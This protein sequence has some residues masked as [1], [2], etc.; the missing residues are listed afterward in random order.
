M[1]VSA[2]QRYRPVYAVAGFYLLLGLVSR[3]LLW[4][5]YGGAADVPAALLPGILAGGLVNDFVE[6]LYLTAPLALC[7]MLLPDR[8][9]RL[10]FSRRLMLAAVAAAVAVLT[11]LAIVEY[12]FFQEFDARFNVVAVDYL[13]YPGEVAG[14]IWAEY[15]VIRAALLAALVMA[16]MIWRLRRPVAAAHDVTVRWRQRAWPLLSHALALGIA[17]AAYPTDA[18][19]WSSNR[20]TND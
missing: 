6:G 4:W 19:S 9:F 20:V 2:L 17:I 8:W 3:C 5:L 11:Y 16:L 12:Y 14:D 1:N 15:P 13:I 7:I 18:L 10:R